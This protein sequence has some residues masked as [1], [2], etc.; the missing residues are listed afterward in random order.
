[1]KEIKVPLSTFVLGDNFFFMEKS[2]RPIYGPE[3]VGGKRPIIGYIIDKNDN[4]EK[5]E[6]IIEFADRHKDKWESNG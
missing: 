3:F 4:V 2:I 1:M 5:F 6:V